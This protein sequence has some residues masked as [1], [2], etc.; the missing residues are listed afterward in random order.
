MKIMKRSFFLH[1]INFFADSIE[2]GTQILKIEEYDEEEEIKRKLQEREEEER[3]EKREKVTI[4]IGTILFIVAIISGN[5]SLQIRLILSII[6]YI[7]LGWDVVLKSFKNITKGNF[8]D[9]NFLMTIATFGAFYLNESTEAVGVMLFY[10][11][12][13]Y[14][15]DKAVSNSRKSIEKLLDIR[16]DYAN[17]KGENG[18]LLTISPKKLKK[19][20]IIV[21]KAGEK[22]P[23]DGIV[24]KGES[25]LNTSALT[26]ESLPLEVNINSE[27]LS[28]SINGN[29]ILEVS[30]SLILQLI[31]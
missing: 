30:F 17:I 11:I 26:G 22:I 7:I 12:G 10:K 14:F 23:V 19:G 5:I 1:E 24:V 9:E 18:E 15:Q 4:I 25:T 21:V 3:R 6:A 28:G 20:D 8:M 27:V 2:P 13:E 16:P 29:G 31:R